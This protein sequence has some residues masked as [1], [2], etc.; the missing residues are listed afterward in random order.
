MDQPIKEEN[1]SIDDEDSIVNGISLNN[2]ERKIML[3]I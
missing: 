1:T 3:R 2:I